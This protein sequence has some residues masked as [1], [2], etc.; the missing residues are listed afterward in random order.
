MYVTL[1]LL[2][3]SKY[4]YIKRDLP[5][6]FTS[7]SPHRTGQ[8]ICWERYV[9]VCRKTIMLIRA[10]TSGKIF[11]STI[12]LP[13]TCLSTPSFICIIYV[14]IMF[15]GLYFMSE[16]YRVHYNDPLPRKPKGQVL[17]PL[18]CNRANARR[19]KGTTIVSRPF[20]TWRST[21]PTGTTCHNTV[22]I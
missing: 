10:D 13:R 12:S 11:T 18:G 9:D 3:L 14:L 7:V 19:E 4:M 8:I 6:E 15:V 1:L 20:Y 22:V 5:R 16:P 2:A 21:Q 17:R